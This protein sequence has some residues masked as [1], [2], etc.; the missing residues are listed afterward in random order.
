MSRFWYTLYHIIFLQ[1]RGKPQKISQRKNKNEILYD[2]YQRAKQSEQFANSD[3]GRQNRIRAYQS[4]AQ[5]VLTTTVF[6]CATRFFVLVPCVQTFIHTSF[7]VLS[8]KPDEP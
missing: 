2:T 1:A 4:Y 6:G 3:E 8:E 5:S 7:F